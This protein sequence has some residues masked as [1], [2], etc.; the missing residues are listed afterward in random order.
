MRPR[1]D[2]VRLRTR[3]MPN[4]FFEAEAEAN[5]LENISVCMSMKT[6]ILAFRT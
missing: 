3:P 1:P 2:R 4:N 5:T 6:M